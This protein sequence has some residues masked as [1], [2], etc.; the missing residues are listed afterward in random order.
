MSGHADAIGHVGE[1]ERAEM[2]AVVDRLVRD[3]IGPRAAEIDASAEFPTDVYA[4]I[5]EIGLFAAF[6]PPEY[7]GLPVDLTT[8]LLAVE[9]IAAASAACG[10]MLGNCGDGIGA[11]VLGGTDVQKA[12]VLPGVA[13]GSI[14][15]CFCLTEPDGGSDAAGLRTTAVP[16]GDRFRLTGSKL[17]ITNGSVGDSFTVWARSEAGISA[18]LV[19][20]GAAGLQSVRDEDLL[21]LRGLPAT[22]LVFDSTPAE[23]LGVEGEGFKLAMAT[24]DEARLN[25]SAC[26]L[27]TARAAL[28]I[29]VD[30]ARVREAFGQPIIRH[31]GLGFLLADVV[32]K[33][34]AARALWLQA[35]QMVQS[36]AG[37]GASTLCAMA[38][39][40]CCE[41]AMVATTEAVQVMG[42]MG[43]TKSVPVERMFRDAKTFQILDGTTQIQQ[44]IISRH[45]ERS[46]LPF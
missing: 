14:V 9:R 23:L 31:Q 40:A 3:L 35:V 36:G 13:D 4:A 7:G 45:L 10:V 43:L 27:G 29:A 39:N 46:G 1:A 44:V 2:L 37:R 22:E 41:A 19:E 12:R 17:Y 32:T 18:F 20:R 11:I 24:L 21:G 33:V 16:D 38:K 8:V 15:P 26:A 34:A 42:G 25:I 30:H 28:E 5:A 6:V